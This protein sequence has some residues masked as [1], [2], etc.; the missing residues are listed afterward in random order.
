M[1]AQKVVGLCPNCG[2]RLGDLDR[3]CPSCGAVISSQ[4]LLPTMAASDVGAAPPTVPIGRIETPSSSALVAFAPGAMLAGRYRIIGL[5]G[6]GG[7]GEVYRADDLTLGQPVALKCLPKALAADPVK[8]ER[9]LGE[10]RIARQVS[11]PNMCRVYDIAEIDGRHFL[12]M[13]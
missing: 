6:R 12:T 3:P 11:H 13:E 8:R 2:A 1:G 5:L 9:L 10:V 4:S 7:M